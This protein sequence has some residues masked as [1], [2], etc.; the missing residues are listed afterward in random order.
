[1]EHYNNKFDVEKLMQWPC[2]LTKKST[3]FVSCKLFVKSSYTLGEKTHY[4]F[5]GAKYS[6]VL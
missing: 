4:I 6:V 1:M 3:I 2:L 5:Y